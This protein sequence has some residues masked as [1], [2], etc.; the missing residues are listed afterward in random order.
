MLLNKSDLFGL[1]DNA[2]EIIS[3]F[4]VNITNKAFLPQLLSP[5]VSRVR[6]KAISN[7]LKVSKN[8]KFPPGIER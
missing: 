2:F 8:S 7:S 6:E 4:C 1:W 3:I 5:F